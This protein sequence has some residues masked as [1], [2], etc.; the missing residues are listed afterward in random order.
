MAVAVAVPLPLHGMI[1]DDDFK[2]DGNFGFEDRNTLQRLVFVLY[3][4]L[5]GEPALY[6]HGPCGL[7]IKGLIRPAFYSGSEAI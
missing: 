3:I 7:S 6:I 1:D 4:H 2:H 5:D